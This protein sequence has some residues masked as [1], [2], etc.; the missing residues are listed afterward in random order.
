MLP[1]DRK[2]VQDG[3]GNNVGDTTFTDNLL[4]NE[5]EKASQKGFL[6]RYWY[7]LLPL[8]IMSL[9]GEAPPEPDQQGQRGGASQQGGGAGVATATAATAAAVGG[10]NAAARQ[11]RGK[12]N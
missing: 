10:G 9:F 3:T 6:A 1:R 11:R 4:M 2:K 8:A 7:I 5:E 12:R